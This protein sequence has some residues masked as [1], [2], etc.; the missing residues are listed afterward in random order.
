MWKSMLRSRKRGHWNQEVVSGVHGG[1]EGG[2]VM[3]EG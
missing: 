2:L 3:R 1:L